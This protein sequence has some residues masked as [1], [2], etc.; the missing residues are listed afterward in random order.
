MRDGAVH[1]PLHFFNGGIKAMFAVMREHVRLVKSA[2]DTNTYVIVDD[3]PPCTPSL[4]VDSV[5]VRLGAPAPGADLA[6]ADACNS[7]NSR[8]ECPLPL[9]LIS[10]P[11]TSLHPLA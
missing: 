10:V 4:S 1:P 5:D 11:R 7:V 3:G 6:E 9:E 2:A 8:F